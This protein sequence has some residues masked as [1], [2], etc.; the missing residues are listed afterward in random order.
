[1]IALGPREIPI[2]GVV[3]AEANG[4]RW[5]DLSIREGWDDMIVKIVLRLKV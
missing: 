2:T 5:G 4:L 1:M 3:E